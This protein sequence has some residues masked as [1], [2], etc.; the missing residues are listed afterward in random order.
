M[1]C[2]VC[3][4]EEGCFRCCPMTHGTVCIHGKLVSESCPYC[5]LSVERG[6]P[7]DAPKNAS[8]HQFTGI[9]SLNHEPDWI[10]ERAKGQLKQVLGI[11]YSKEDDSFFFSGSHSDGPENLWLLAVAQKKLIEITGE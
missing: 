6:A 10:L 2:E 9:T 1:T 7:V 3:N 4:S 8:I 5:D 11:G